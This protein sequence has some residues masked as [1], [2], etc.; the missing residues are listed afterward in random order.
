MFPEV[1]AQALSDR[2]AAEAQGGT[3]VG[4]A[5]GLVPR[6]ANPSDI[7]C[8]TPEVA[9]RTAK[10]NRLD[11]SRKLLPA[12]ARVGTRRVALTLAGGSP[13]EGERGLIVVSGT[14][15][16]AGERATTAAT[17]DSL[18]KQSVDIPQPFGVIRLAQWSLADGAPVPA[19]EV[20]T[21]EDVR[22]LAA[23]P[24][25]SQVYAGDG[26]RTVR[27]ERGPNLG[28]DHYPIVAILAPLVREFL[29]S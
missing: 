4:C 2:A 9:A 27:V 24:G 5:D 15:I 12:A 11:E 13:V 21:L 22:V 1:R 29:A 3:A 18:T 23:Q 16:I 28:S 17:G 10:E 20:G 7:A 6:R 8:S 19:S 26:L 14:S 25:T